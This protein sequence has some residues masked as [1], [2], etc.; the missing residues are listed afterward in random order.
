[1]SSHGAVQ[2]VEPKISGGL[3]IIIVLIWLTIGTKINLVLTL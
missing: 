2:G 1:M 3:R